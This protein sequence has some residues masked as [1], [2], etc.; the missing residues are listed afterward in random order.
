MTGLAAAKSYRSPRSLNVL[1]AGGYP[2]GTVASV[3]C[4]CVWLAAAIWVL[5]WFSV[6]PSLASMVCEVW[7]ACAM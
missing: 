2:A 1:L 7:I 5:L 4:R 3:M 6:K